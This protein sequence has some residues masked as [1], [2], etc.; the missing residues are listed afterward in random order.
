MPCPNHVT[1][2]TASC[3]WSSV[4]IL[5][6]SH[7]WLLAAIE[8]I[9]WNNIISKFGTFSYI[10]CYNGDV[11]KF[12]LSLDFLH[13][14]MAIIIAGEVTGNRLTGLVQSYFIKKSEFLNLSLTYYRVC[15]ITNC[16]CQEVIQSSQISQESFN[17]FRFISAAVPSKNAVSANMKHSIYFY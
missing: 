6:L 13:F 8:V 17:Q 5:F 9:H 14:V 3:C 4:H 16:P 2:E 11:F 10:E 7:N 12:L 1:C 15:E